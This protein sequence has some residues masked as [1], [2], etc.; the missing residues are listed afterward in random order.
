MTDTP[1]PFG[2]HVM[3]KPRGAVCNLACEY[4]FYL[5]KEQLY[6][7]ADLRMTDALL[8]EYT[9]QYIEAQGAPEATF[10]WQGGEP[11]LMGLDFFRKAVALQEK[12]CRPGMKILN[13]F[14]TNGILLDEEWCRFFH[15]NHFLV[16]LSIDGPRALHDRYRRDKGEQPT[17]ERVMAAADLLRAHQVEFNTLTC[18]SAANAPHGLEVY[19]FLRDTVQ[20]RFMQFIPII[21]RENVT[22]FQEGLRL[23]NRSIT[24]SQYGRFL[25]DIFDEWVRRDVGRVSVQMFD[26]AL[27]AWYGQRAGMCVYEET[28]G[29]AMAMEFNGD[30]YA[31]DHFVEPRFFIGNINE[32]PLA[33]M[34]ASR[35]MQEFG[36]Y[37]RRRLPAFCQQCAVRFA[38]NGGCPKDRVLS[39][40]DGEPGLN[41]LCSGYRAFY[42]Y[43]DRPMKLMA[44]FLRAGRAPAEICRIIAKE[45]PLREQPPDTPCPC[46]SGKPVDDCHR[47]QAASLPKSRKRH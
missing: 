42:T 29:S 17:H 34:A 32:T 5:K 44:G 40:P 47:K 1:A 15:D 28:C 8:E 26:S 39:T 27:A 22:G 13:A 4:C 3:V 23:T 10:A 9:R 41:A 45:P 12:Y 20:S 6:P 24:G 2:F 36:E 31:C 43:V 30:V 21:E 11:T 38:C 33:V 46:G 35:K 16:G 7:G 19:A 14:Q 25:I 18:V 37:K